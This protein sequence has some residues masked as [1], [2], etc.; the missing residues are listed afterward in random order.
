MIYDIDE[1]R[2]Y[3]VINCV[4]THEVIL[5][6]K[7]KY[8]PGQPWMYF[9]PENIEEEKVTNTMRAPRQ[10]QVFETLE[11]AKRVAKERLLKKKK[12][13]PD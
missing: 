11:E 10:D 3:Y 2:T 12:P 5:V 13:S 6:G 9:H 4:E 7:L 8:I 1:T